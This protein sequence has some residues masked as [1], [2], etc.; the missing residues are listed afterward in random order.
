MK[1]TLT[2][3]Q[4]EAMLR[5]LR[6]AVLRIPTRIPDLL[7]SAYATRR[8]MPMGS[9]RPGRWS[10]DLTPFWI[11]VMDALS[12]TS[13]VQRGVILKSAQI[14]ATAIAEI[15]L[16]YYMDVL[17]SD[18]LFL[19]ANE[20]LLERWASRRLEK[21]I[22]SFGIRP[23]IY[24]SVDNAKSRRTGDKAFSKEY[25]G[26][27]LDLA[28]ARSAAQQR[29]TDKR[30]LLRDEIDGAP[31]LLTTGEGYFLDVSWARTN[32]WGHRRKVLDFGTPTTYDASEIW[33]A[34]L[35]GDQCVYHVPCPH[36]GALQELQFGDE[37]TQH[38]LKAETQAGTFVR[39]Y[40]LCDHCHDAIFEHHKYAANLKGD[41]I[42]GAM[43][44][45]PYW[46]SWRI[47]SLYSPFM[48]W[49]DLWRQWDA[50]L[51]KPD[52]MRSF[53]NL[54]SGMPY[55]ETG[56]RPRME[57]VISLRSG[58]QRGTVPEGVVYLTFGLDVQRGST[59][60]G[61]L[62][63]RLELEILGTGRGYRTWSIDY[64]V[65]EGEIE[66]PH[67]GAWEA[68]HQMA[69]E[70]KFNYTLADGRVVT[71]RLGLA[72]TGDQ[73]EHTHT[74]IRFCERWANTFPSKGFGSLKRRHGEQIDEA[75]PKDFTRYRVSRMKD[76]E[77]FYAISTN[78]Y[79][80]LVYSNL[81]L[82]RT[83]TGDPPPG[84]CEFPMDYPER[85]FEM[86]TAEEMKA[87][88]SF[89]A[90]GRRNEA[91]DCRVMALCAADIYLD[92]LVESIRATARLRGA[93]EVEVTQIGKRD[94]LDWL[95]D[96]C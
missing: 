61:K 76:G 65:V 19:S 92:S 82:T 43:S 28:S 30:I 18:I 67:S 48:S 1:I 37:R 51:K 47:S 70:G 36:C 8:I 80:R 32:A 60:E 17:P 77:K 86:L 89:D 72:D 93:S 46:K 91:I 25:S 57:N 21:A 68:L 39:A 54:Y 95:S 45:N 35:D 27:Q 52:G 9:P 56:S 58:Y 26:C 62:P 66:D 33:K 90:G 79:K 42:P 3:E 44:S 41:W 6:K 34:F 31:A 13:P 75:S 85:Y 15:I 64:V 71:P 10:N 40:Y 5:A 74:V 22:D 29:A 96:N 24:S 50:A 94:A 16:C 7:I 59:K 2:P 63:A 11:S 49:D 12:P 4:R 84:F 69:M 81:K 20:K 53:I 38:G 14:G 73:G 55:R 88:G 78:Y 87:D 23:K 83:E